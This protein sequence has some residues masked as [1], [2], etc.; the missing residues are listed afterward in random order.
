M[1]GDGHDYVR[2]LLAACDLWLRSLDLM[3][4]HLPSED[5]DLIAP[6][7]MAPMMIDSVLKELAP[8]DLTAPERSSV[9]ALQKLLQDRHD[10]IKQTQP[11]GAEGKARH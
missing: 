5:S 1:T 7:L 11:D 9:E 2:D 10:A 6:L 3:D 4:R 8:R